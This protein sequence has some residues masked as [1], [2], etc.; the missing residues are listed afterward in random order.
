MNDKNVKHQ[1]TN[2][3]YEHKD[4]NIKKTVLIGLA[5]ILVIVISLVVLNEYFISVKEGL[6]YDMVLKPQSTALRDFRARE[7]ET[8]NSYKLLDSTAGR[9]Q[10]PI[11]RA[12]ELIAEEAY[13]G[14]K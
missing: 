12:M 1:A 13:K 8:L 11:S 7:D 2:D 10:V 4:I 9:Y 3:G 6:V 14:L 5:I